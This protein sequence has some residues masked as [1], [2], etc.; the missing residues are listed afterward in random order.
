MIKI[1]T[2]KSFFNKDLNEIL[3]N[4]DIVSNEYILNAGTMMLKI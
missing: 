2:S 3:N 1:T 4:N